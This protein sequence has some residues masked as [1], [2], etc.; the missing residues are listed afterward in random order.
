MAPV[1]K[2]RVP[3]YDHSPQTCKVTLLLCFGCHLEIVS[4]VSMQISILSLVYHS[5]VDRAI[6]AT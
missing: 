1:A 4:A 2:I 6:V 3:F 5:V